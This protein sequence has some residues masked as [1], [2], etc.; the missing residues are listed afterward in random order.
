MRFTIAIPAF[1][2]KFLSQCIQSVLD[3]QFKDFELIIVND[4]SPD[5]L[6]EIVEKFDDDRILYF[7]NKINTGAENVVDNWNLCLSYS[8]GDYIVLLGDDDFMKPNYLTVFNNLIEKYA[9]HNVYH[10]RSYI[11]NDNSE[12][13]GLT[14]SWPRWES[15]YENMWHRMNKFRSQY[16]SD[17]VYK[18]EF[19][20]HIG[21]YYKLPLAWASDDITAYLA[22]VDKGIIHSQEPV[23]CYRE[24]N[25]TIS[26]SGSV[27]LKIKAIIEEE[28]WF[29]SFLQNNIP[30]NNLDQYFY[31]M[32]KNEK[33]KYFLKKRIDTIAYNGLRKGYYMKD[34]IKFVSKKSDY[35]LS[36]QHILYAV[37]LAFKKERSKTI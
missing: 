32:I 28:K 1:K 23:F 12:I 16:I 17:F 21:G 5:N 35:N 15:V 3:Q 8:K 27:G 11:I 29:D 20:I 24:S 36:I 2:G 31:K 33:D 10:C 25:I 13:I 30:E 22:A 7:K 9:D 6:D 14:P 34:I 18:R 19:L 4:A 37:I 26:N